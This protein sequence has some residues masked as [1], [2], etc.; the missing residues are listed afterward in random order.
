YRSGVEIGRAP[1]GGLEHVSGSHA[2]SALQTVDTEGR[3]S[4]LSVTSVGGATPDLKALAS[5]MKV[6][7]QILAST[8]AL[9][10]PGTS[11]ILTDAPVNANTHDT[12]DRS[13]LTTSAN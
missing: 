13:I 8:R 10:V 2:F 3:R 11:L 7:P 12:S 5:R 1:V 4:W 9:I 6:D